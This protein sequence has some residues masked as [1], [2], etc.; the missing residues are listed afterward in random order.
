MAYGQPYIMITQK[1]VHLHV[2]LSNNVHHVQNII[3][4]SLAT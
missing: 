1:G 4:V 3:T 2:D